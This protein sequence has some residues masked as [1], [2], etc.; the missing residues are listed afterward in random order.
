V[1]P[2]TH[3]ITNPRGRPQPKDAPEPIHA[4]GVPLLTLPEPLSTSLTT[5]PWTPGTYVFANAY[6]WALYHTNPAFQ[7]ALQHTQAIFPDGIGSLIPAKLHSGQI[8]K[9]IP[10]PNFAHAALK[11][12][13][14]KPMTFI[15]GTHTG[16]L[17]LVEKYQLTHATQLIPPMQN[18]SPEKTLQDLKNLPN[19]PPQS[20][21]WVC[22]GCPKQELW[23]QEASK[24]LPNHIFFSIGAAFDF[25]SGEKPRAPLRLQQLG[26]EWA[27][28]LF[29]EPNRLLKRCLYGNLRLLTYTVL[30][31]LNP[32][33]IPKPNN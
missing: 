13:N 26:L 31:K 23:A 21:I 16:F 15:G 32:K 27:Y 30:Y 12:W 33:K 20:I 14:K 28:R 5:H 3:I 11:A 7:S 4:F 29:Q 18:V 8:P 1:P 10:G 25:L 6:S 22:L 17:K 19:L 24:Y 9:R 2:P